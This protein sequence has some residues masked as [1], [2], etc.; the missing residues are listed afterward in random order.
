MVQV[1]RYHNLHDLSFRC[2][3]FI[4]Q[5]AG[6]VKIAVAL[7]ATSKFVTQQGWWFGQHHYTIFSAKYDLEK[8]HRKR[9][10]IL[11]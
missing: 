8:F 3:W 9:D 4:N 2:H 6:A 10:A 5:L 7:P 1:V 11:H